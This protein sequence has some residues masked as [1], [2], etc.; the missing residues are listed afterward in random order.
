MMISRTANIIQKSLM[1]VCCIGSIFCLI[2]K[3]VSFPVQTLLFVVL[4]LTCIWHIFMT[5]CPHCKRFGGIKPKP[6]AKDAGRCIHCGE[7]VEYK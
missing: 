1:L 5:R 4:I 3:S 6:F 2:S 7:L